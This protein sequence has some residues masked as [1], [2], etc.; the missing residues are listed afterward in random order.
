MLSSRLPTTAL[1][2]LSIALSEVACGGS[3]SSEPTRTPDTDAGVDAIPDAPTAEASDDDASP[4]VANEVSLSFPQALS[5]AMLAN[6]DVVPILPLRI[7]VA[8]SPDTVRVSVAGATVDATDADGDGT[9]EALIP[10]ASQ[11]DGELALSA[12]AELGG[13]AVATVDAELRIE[14]EGVQVTD[15]ATDGPAGTPRL[16]RIGDKAWLT[17]TDRSSGSPDAWLQEVDG[18]G[19]FVGARSSLIGATATPALYARTLPGNDYVGVLFQ[20]LATPY[21]THFRVVDLL[22]NT[23]VDTM[24]LDPPGANAS[25][26]GDIAF[27]GQAF[28]IAW[29]VFD[30]AGSQVLWQRIDPT[31]AQVTGPVV[32]AE[33]GDDNPVGGFEPFSFVKLATAGT[34]SLVTFV[35][36]RWIPLLDM[37]VPKAQFARVA[38][39]GTVDVSG[40]LAGETDFTWHREARVTRV[41]QSFLLLWSSVDLNDP[42]TNPPNLFQA[43]LADAQGELGSGPPTLVFDAVDDR[44]E[45]FALPHPDHFATLA[46]LD[47]RAYTTDPAHGRIELYVAAMGD[48]LTTGEP[49][50]FPH[51][52]FVAGLAQL[53]GAPLGSNVMLTWID[54]RHG[55]GIADPKPE[56][57]LETAWY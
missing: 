19:R 56:V 10:I 40:Y 43:L 28:V 14:R 16:H 1:L 23:V 26:G 38:Q 6:P 18:A 44:D 41:G 29:R 13:S 55:S 33:S 3:E 54:E 32:V 46:W 42:S 36:G 7:D 51:A 39:D 50:V 34:V 53:N 12:V 20:S 21:Q 22:G 57:W 8:G 45:P 4:D 47:H 9:W 52:R 49:T 27:D 35:R 30:A 25:F 15:F 11:A 37:S 5:G 2:A 24:D 31:N 17:W 48:D